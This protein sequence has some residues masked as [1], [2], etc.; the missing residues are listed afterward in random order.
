MKKLAIYGLLITTFVFSLSLFTND[1]Q[2]RTKPAPIIKVNDLADEV[3]KLEDQVDAYKNQINSLGTSVANKDSLI[4]SLKGQVTAL[5]QAL[6]RTT[7]YISI[8]SP[9]AGKVINSKEKMDI[10]WKGVNLS[11]AT[12]D[13]YLAVKDSPAILVANVPNSGSASVTLP[14][15][16]PNGS[17]YLT[18]TAKDLVVDGKPVSRQVKTPFKIADKSTQSISVS[19]LTTSDKTANKVARG[20]EAVLTFMTSN[21]PAGTMLNVYIAS[22]TENNS[23]EA[24]LVKEVKSTSA[25]QAVRFVVPNSVTLGDHKVFVSVKATPSVVAYSTNSITVTGSGS[26]SNTPAVTSSTTVSIIS[27]SGDDY[28]VVAGKNLFVKIAGTFINSDKEKIAV[29]EVQ[30]TT[31]NAKTVIAS[32]K[33]KDF[34]SG[35][36]IKVPTNIANGVYKVRITFTTASESFVKES[37]RF[38]IVSLGANAGVEA[39]LTVTIKK[40]PNPVLTTKASASIT[41][42]ASVVGATVAITDRV[43]FN[44]VDSAGNLVTQLGSERR[45]RE[46]PVEGQACTNLMTSGVARSI[47]KGTP[48]GSYKIQIV[49]TKP[50]S[51][52]TPIVT[53]YSDAFTVTN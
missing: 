48:S 13:V 26:G 37:G 17:Y 24:T 16:L 18:L 6:N 41:L 42:Q 19:A 2:A 12:I 25:S 47:P 9:K 5:T 50:D 49:I 39:A 23:N 36:N 51:G 29:V 22:S 27:P 7:P 30:N 52:R 10:K 33:V 53:G 32:E 1:A 28:S 3:D 45:I 8:L 38:S 35:K 11:G 46:C 31:T 34:L 44:L 15:D 14:S 43:K 4:N 20:G 21:I 40:I